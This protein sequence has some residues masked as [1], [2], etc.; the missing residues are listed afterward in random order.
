M[1]IE[2]G[3]ILGILLIWGIFNLL[4]VIIYTIKHR[5]DEKK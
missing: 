3:I 5:K 1:Q 2:Y 4:P